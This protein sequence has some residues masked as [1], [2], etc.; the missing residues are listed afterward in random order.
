LSQFT[1]TAGTGVAFR[2]CE[3]IFSD[4][5]TWPASPS[6]AAGGIV[7]E[8]V[9]VCRYNGEAVPLGRGQTVFDRARRWEIIKANATERN[10]A[11]SFEKTTPSTETASEPGKKYFTVAEA[12]QALPYVSRIIEDVTAAYQRI[13]ELRRQLERAEPGANEEVE[14]EYE[15]TMDRLSK[16]VDELHD[17]GVE[18]KDFEKGLIDFPAWHEGREILLCWKQG[19]EEVGYW[20]ETDAGYAGRQS[21]QVLQEPA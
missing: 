17:V 11:M 20:H 19:E 4:V 6:V 9:I 3:G 16:L 7:N 1:Q 21:V 5:G 12:N 13:V 18:L 2:G 8:A 15:Q 14:R 10:P